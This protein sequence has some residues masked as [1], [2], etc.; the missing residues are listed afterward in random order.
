MTCKAALKACIALTPASGLSL[1]AGR[2]TEDITVHPE[3]AQLSQDSVRGDIT[4]HAET[5]RHSLS[6]R[7]QVS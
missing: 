4:A 1:S 5:P 7:L 6:H 2:V 3:M